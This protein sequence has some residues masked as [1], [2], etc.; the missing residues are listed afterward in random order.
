M[1]QLSVLRFEIAKEADF[2]E[3][4]PFEIVRLVDDQHHGAPLVS[5]DHEHLIERKQ[6]FCF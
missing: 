2:F 3:D 5:L 1:K 6:N 4:V